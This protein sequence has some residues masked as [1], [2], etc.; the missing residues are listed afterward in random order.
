M[1]VEKRSCESWVLSSEF[2][3]LKNQFNFLNKEKLEYMVD[4]DKYN[5]LIQEGRNGVG[6]YEAKVRKLEPIIRDIPFEREKFRYENG[7]V[8]RKLVKRWVVEGT[9]ERRANNK[10][11][12]LKD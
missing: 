6:Y 1:N 8:F 5:F 10:E 11:L 12:D 9:E 7:N 3:T 2:K 4:K